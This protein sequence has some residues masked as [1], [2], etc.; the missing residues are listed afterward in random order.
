MADDADD[1]TR[2]REGFPA[3]R[4]LTYLSICDKTSCMMRCAP[5]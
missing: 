1:F 2:F 4:H 5:A 3:L